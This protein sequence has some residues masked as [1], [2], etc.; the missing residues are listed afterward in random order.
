MSGDRPA[1]AQI[2]PKL[3]V[4]D[5]VRANRLAM[6][7]LFEKV[8]ADVI[9]AESGSEALQACLDHEFALILLDVQMPG[10]DGFEVASVLASSPDTREVPIIFVTAAFAD[11]INR[12]KGYQL[13]AVDYI[14]KPVNDV[15]LM[16]KVEVFLELWRSKQQLLELLDELG[17]RNRQL[18]AEIAERKRVESL[19]RHQAQHDSLTGLPNRLLFLDRADTA[20]SRAARSCEA[21]AIL[22]LD[23]DGFKAINDTYGHAAGD[24]LL[25]QVGRRL[26]AGIRKCDTVARLSGDEFA[27]V[28]EDVLSAAMALSVAEKLC[29]SVAESY[30]ISPSAMVD[31]ESGQ[32]IPPAGPVWVRISVSVGVAV[33]PEHGRTPEALTNAADAAMYLAKRSGKNCAR[34]AE[35]SGHRN[36]VPSQA[37]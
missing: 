25:V 27:V 13:G 3:L 19:V 12:L 16:S 29:D 2:R 17:E 34:L 9:E 14:A 4:V 18:E 20:A 28:L 26:G 31:A 8:E 21:F 36:E 35:S 7:L 6:R 24:D 30:Y 10:M 37:S 32:L 1:T 5:D 33:F 11:D 22:F 23:L 15:I